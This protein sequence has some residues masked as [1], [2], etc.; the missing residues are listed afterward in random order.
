L[1][2]NGF[3]ERAGGA[4]MQQTM[5]PGQFRGRIGF[6][7]ELARHLHESG[8][9]VN[10]LEGAVERASRKL[11]LEVGIWSSPTGIII[12]FNDQ[13]NGE[14]FTITRVLRLHP[15]ETNL[16]RMADADAIA[17]QVIDGRLGIA[18]GMERLREIDRQPPGFYRAVQ[19]GCFGIAS[20]MVVCLLPGTGWN[21][22]LTSVI[23]GALIGVLTQLG[24]RRQ[25]LFDAVE[26]I[27]AFMV[28]FAA[29]YLASHVIPLSV[30]AV[31]ISALIILMPGLMLTTAIGELAN[32]QLA[33]GSARFAGAVTVLLKLTFGSMLAAQFVDLLGWQNLSN[34]GVPA[35][36]QWMSL[37]MLVP[38]A[39][40]LAVLFK[41][42]ARD[43]PIAMLSVFLGF[44]VMKACSLVPGLSGGDIPIGAFLAAFAVTTASNLYARLFSRPGALIRVPGIILLVPGSLGFQIMNTAM[45]AD[46]G[47]RVGIAIPLFAAL[48]ALVAGILFGNLLVS[49]RRNL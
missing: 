20:A 44:G 31:T 26:A 8:T 37:A 12:S 22:L 36:P 43:I 21:D 47:Y 46:A 30:N 23:L 2:Y 32:Q 14:P 17:E 15:G 33:S 34:S 7:M 6:V 40:A 1:T 35:L 48:S 10:R 42:H 25:Q 19:A 16:G 29:S 49:S 13:L 41:T 18:D 45:T 39:L 27:A 5:D 28:T 24:A 4:D 38:G 9:T 11:G 3:I